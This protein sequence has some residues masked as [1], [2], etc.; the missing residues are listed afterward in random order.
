MIKPLEKI[1]PVAQGAFAIKNRLLE[2]GFSSN[3]K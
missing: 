1:Q 2:D 3:Q